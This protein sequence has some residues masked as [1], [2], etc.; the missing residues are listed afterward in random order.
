MIKK[1]LFITLVVS[2]YQ[3]WY[4]PAFAVKA[5]PFP[6]IFT[7]PDGTQLTIRLSGNEFFH[8]RTTEDGYLI[9]NNTKGYLTYATV[10][11][12]G[13]IIESNYIAR[14][15]SKRSVSDIEYLKTINKTAQIQT[16]QNTSRKSKMLVT[17]N[18]PQR[19][20][21]LNGSP[22]ALVILVNFKDTSFVTPSPKIAFTNLLNQDGY[23]TNGGTG[24]ARDYFMS[25][26]YGK[27]SPTF[28]VV[29]PYTLPNNMA[30]YG[31]NDAAGHD[32]NPRQMIIDACTLASKDG[33]N[34]SLYDTDNNGFVDNVFV[35]YAGY[36]EAEDL[37]T[38]NKNANTIWPHRWTLADYS[39]Q[40][41]GKIVYDYSCTSELKGYTGTNMC[42]IGTFCHE[43]GH[44]LGLV[45][46]YHT[47]ADVHTLD[48]WDIMDA[49]PYLNG[50]RTPPTYSAYERFFLGYST[51]EQ[52]STPSNKTLLPIYQGKTPP[53]N[54]NNQAYL[55]SATTHNMNGASPNPAEF[56][57]LEYRKKIGWDTY[58]P[59]EGMLVWH[60]D[61]D[62][63]A[64]VSNTVNNYTGTTQTAASHMRVYLQP[65]VGSTSTPGTAFTSG[66]FT[67]ITWSGV[68]INRAIINITKTTDTITFDFM[69]AKISTTGSFTAFQTTLGTVSAT[70]NLVISAL[71]LSGNLNVTLQNNTNFEVKLSTDAIWSK[72]LN[73]VPASGGVTSTLQVHYN[74]IT[75]GDHT[76]QLD[77]SSDGL[78]PV[79]FNLSGTTN[80]GSN[81]PVIFAGKIDN[82]LSFSATK[83]NNTDTK[84]INIKSTYLNDNLNLSITGTDASMFTVSVR[85]ITKDAANAS[86]GINITVNYKPTVVGIHTA[87]FIISGGGLNQNKVIVLTG[88]GI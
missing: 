78:A 22:R 87:T 17:I 3:I 26:S 55:F 68:D 66:S 70:Q 45:D 38:N 24:S 19:A 20:Y 60:I 30:F 12:T 14:D 5:Y 59:A 48:Y 54:T 23:S 16:L 39:T 80:V 61:Y 11:A 76:D 52:I 15:A 6:F 41:N 83:L 10:T 46:F 34:F 62:Q 31:A 65:L 85:T 79:S 42:G 69:P 50:G 36:N 75:I 56:F 84:T 57:M 82:S 58:L 43:F 51:P 18:Q 27:F 29:G 53:T 9:K 71:N 32:V 64:W 40:F 25:S 67:P 44:V 28:D 7:Q 77:I 13:E 33:V 86:A 37:S 81:S 21:P 63:A 72:S 35:Y 1:V 4:L 2:F 47:T 73:I 88:S 49:G 74:P 8:F